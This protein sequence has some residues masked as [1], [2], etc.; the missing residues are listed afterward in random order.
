MAEM[1]EVRLNR[2]LLSPAN[3]I[4]G[5]TLCAGMANEPIVGAYITEGGQDPNGIVLPAD[6]GIR[7]ILKAILHARTLDDTEEVLTAMGQAVP[8]LSA[9]GD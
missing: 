4:G 1:L 2:W 9:Q 6:D 7:L 5:L 8:M 3:I